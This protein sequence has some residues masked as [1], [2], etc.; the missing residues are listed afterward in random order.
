MLS[1]SHAF[2]LGPMAVKCGMRAEQ[3]ISLL[4]GGSSRNSK[5]SPSPTN[6]AHQ[7]LAGLA[8]GGV[9]G[10]HSPTVAEDQAQEN[11]WRHI[12]VLQGH[13]GGR[14][15]SRSPEPLA[16]TPIATVRK[17][18]PKSGAPPPAPATVAN[19]VQNVPLLDEF[20]RKNCAY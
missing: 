15:A 13:T 20:L 17:P 16:P 14:R 9:G 8:P 1:R 7:E 12:G 2:W 19:R 10:R 11:G 3:S 6:M 4:T 18:S 5:V